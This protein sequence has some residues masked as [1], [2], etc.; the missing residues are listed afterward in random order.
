MTWNEFYQLWPYTAKHYNGTRRLNTVSDPV[1][2]MTVTEQTKEGYT[3]WHTVATVEKQ[4]DLY[5][6]MDLLENIPYRRKVRCTGRVN[7][8]ATCFGNLPTRVYIVAPNKKQRNIYE[9]KF[10]KGGAK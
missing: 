5:C 2:L 8:S 4:V 1:I 10:R 3:R 6:Y 7:N 9:F